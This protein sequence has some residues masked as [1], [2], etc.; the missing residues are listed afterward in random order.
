MSITKKTKERISMKSI[1]I[2]I[3]VIIGIFSFA[4]MYSGDG[5]I[6]VTGLAVLQSDTEYNLYIRSGVDTENKDLANYRWV[7]VGSGAPTNYVR[8][9]DGDTI[10]ATGRDIPSNYPNMATAAVHDSRQYTPIA[11]GNPVNLG[12]QTSPILVDSSGWVRQANSEGKMIIIGSLHTSGATPSPTSSPSTSGPSYHIVNN[13]GSWYRV[14]G[15]TATPVQNF[16]HP[17][18][19]TIWTTDAS[20]RASS[21]SLRA[22]Q[23][24]IT[25]E[26][27]ADVASFNN[28]Q[29][30]LTDEAIQRFKDD[31]GCAEVTHFVL[32][33]GGRQYWNRGVQVSTIVSSQDINIGGTNSRVTVQT[34]GDSA[35]VTIVAGNDREIYGGLTQE[36]A[37]Q[38]ASNLANQYTIDETRSGASHNNNVVLVKPEG[39]NYRSITYQQDGTRIEQTNVG[40]TG[41]RTSSR[42][43]TFAD[44]S[45]LA[46]TYNDRGEL[47]SGTYY[48]D[49][50]ETR[51]DYGDGGMLDEL[52]S[53]YSENIGSV[54]RALSDHGVR[55]D[56]DIEE[57]TGTVIKIDNGDTVSTIPDTIHT[58]NPSLAGYNIRVT[59]SNRDEV[60]Y[61]SEN[62]VTTYSGT[63]IVDSFE[64][65]DIGKATYTRETTYLTTQTIGDRGHTIEVH[66]G[67]FTRRN[68]ENG[69]E[70]GAEITYDI[71]SRPVSVTGNSREQYDISD[72]LT[73]HGSIDPAAIDR[74]N[75]D[76][77]TENHLKGRG[78]FTLSPITLSRMGD[79]FRNAFDG[80][81]AGRGISNIAGWEDNV[82]RETMDEFFV[83]NVLGQWLS[84]RWE[85]SLCHHWIDDPSSDTLFARTPGGLNGLIAHIEG[86][87]SEP[88][89]HPNGSIE[90]LYKMSYVVDNTFGVERETDPL[91]VGTVEFNIIF[92]GDKTYK[93]YTA[94]KEVDPSEKDTRT[95][96][97]VFFKYSSSNYNRVCIKFK[98]RILSVANEWE[99]EVCNNINQAQA[100]P[101][102][103]TQPQPSSGSGGVTTTGGSGE[104]GGF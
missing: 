4:F 26:D 81:R 90:Y 103:Y 57:V 70:E 5:M 82:W 53:T 78:V 65:N 28:G 58:Q 22:S 36:A 104:T 6:G 99:S 29:F 18:E 31:Y 96:Q 11:G 67:Y 55:D 49:G 86:E 97:D 61:Y 27:L 41:G 74:A 9:D 48:A 44:S 60:S 38:I 79:A 54:L 13:G 12:D 23:Y 7:P 33:Q 2:A 102:S 101:S 66:P 87:R 72:F 1:I 95:G 93:L 80:A 42:E 20:G 14:E 76:P 39:N 34:I 75:L 98:E 16:I 47:Q 88:V 100:A 40:S 30:V 63:A 24:G 32:S 84:G 64:R 92:Y 25:N 91:A 71:N 73:D 50:R 10:R 37:Q 59:R 56:D 69:K 51:L 21:T 19:G 46:E 8:Y 43:F 83:T 94:W 35:S 17:T 62:R 89:V 3:I 45:R 15:P 85:D 68:Y 52:Q 77:T